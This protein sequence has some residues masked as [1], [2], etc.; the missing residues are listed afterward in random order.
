MLHV[1]GTDRRRAR[2]SPEVRSHLVAALWVVAVAFLAPFGAALGQAGGAGA[3]V[4]EPGFARVDSREDRTGVGVWRWSAGLVDT[5]LTEFGD[6][7]RVSLGIGWIDPL[8]AELRWRRADGSETPPLERGV[9]YLLDPRRGRVR[10]LG[11]PPD[12]S[13]LHVRVTAFPSEFPTTFWLHR[14]W[15]PP[16]SANVAQVPREERPVRSDPLSEARLDIAG[17]KTFSV[18]V[19]SQQDLSLEQSLDLSINGRIGRNVT[20]RAVLTDRDTPLQPEGTSAQLQD[21]DRVLVEVEGP[22]ARMRLGDFE[23]YLRPTPFTD[24]RRQLAGVEGSVDTQHARVLA[25]GAT[26]PGAFASKEFLGSEGVQGPYVLQRD[27]AGVADPIV[28]GSETV[29]LDGR[30]LSRGEDADYI[31]DYASGELTFTAR[32]AITAY[33]RIAVD[34]QVADRPYEGRVYRA[35]VESGRRDL[36]DG[37]RP[38]RSLLDGW[39]GRGGQRRGGTGTGTVGRSAAGGTTAPGTATTTMPADGT[40]PGAAD[41]E[42]PAS[43]QSALSVDWLVER[44][45]ANE[46]LGLDLTDAERA[47][48]AAAG[49]AADTLAQG[50]RFVGDG[51]GEY[52]LVSV[53]T[54]AAPFFVYQGPGGGDFLVR[55]DAVLPGQGDYVDSTLVD[56]TGTEITFF[57]FAGREEGDFLPARELAAPESRTLFALRSV[58]GLSDRV[59]FVIDGAVS[60]FDRNTLSNRDDGDNVGTAVELAS[61]VALLPRGPTELGMEVR[62]RNVDRRFEPVGRLEE[63]FF[64]LDWNLDPSRLLSGDRRLTV[65]S[66]FRRGTQRL[67]VEVGQLENTVDFRSKRAVVEGH[68]AWRGLELDGRLLRAR[69][70]DDLTARDGRRDHDRLSLARQG[71]WTG[72]SIRYAHERTETGKSAGRSGS[73]YREVGGRLETGPKIKLV[74]AAVQHSERRT[75]AIEGDDEFR[76]DTG[77]TSTGEVEWRGG[78]GRSVQASYTRRT[79][80]PSG[81]GAGTTSE[82]GSLRWLLRRS[83]GMFRQEGRWELSTQEERERLRVLEF[84]GTGEGHYD[85]LGV[86]QGVGDYEILIRESDEATKRNRISWSSRSELDRGRASTDAAD[87]TIFRRAWNDLRFVHYW[88]ATVETAREVSYLWGRMLPVLWGTRRLERVDVLQRADLTALDQAKYFAPRLGVSIRGTDSGATEGITE[89]ATSRSYSLTL[90]SRPKERWSL[91]M[92]GDLDRDRRTFSSRGATSKTGWDSR[93]VSLDQSVR[94][95]SGLSVEADA[96]YRRRARVESAERADVYEGSP[97]VVWTPQPRSRVEVR[98]KRTSVVRRGGSGRASRELERS[99]W[100]SRVLTTLRLREALD[101]S[102]F[103]H[104]SRPDGGRD[105]RDLRLELRATF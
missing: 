97:A 26:S 90:R 103:F 49:D 77:R 27:I 23:T 60:D 102:F 78:G 30:S 38:G 79:L 36:L 82:L 95:R 35:G 1:R 74:R 6:S 47:V 75:Y 16:D 50:I 9:D 4:A 34:Y 83:D 96:K 48:L 73:F 33:S 89:R 40:S 57:V 100:D 2:V 21:L 86:Y 46:P 69:S 64:G 25:I 28:A 29:W 92:T 8:S 62:F 54:L 3:S 20:V 87:G 71:G 59:S 15:F 14:P 76:S 7:L 24:Y 12:S 37:V 68:S 52:T 63:S 81:G 72:A 22:R 19:G 43:V 11:A 101:L 5:T 67:R 70:E 39:G 94:L 104:E 10:L 51:E 58:T 80:T 84:V 45:A 66:Q 65:A 85:S 93:G 88:T 61:A 31:I 42:R 91:D 99:G 18:Q 17:S 41:R 53:D 32:N 44:D 98:T 56:S 13:A 55:F 105:V